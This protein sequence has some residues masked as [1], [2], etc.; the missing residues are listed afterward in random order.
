[1]ITRRKLN[2]RCINVKLF[3]KSRE[4][5]IGDINDELFGLTE[6]SSTS[7]FLDL[8][9]DLLVIIEIQKFS[10]NLSFHYLCIKKIN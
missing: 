2:T 9:K 6:T 3:R 8:Y 5:I 1:M 10:L 7:S 4:N